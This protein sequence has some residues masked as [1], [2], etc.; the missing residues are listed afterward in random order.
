MKECADA[1]AKRRLERFEDL[2]VATS[3]DQPSSAVAPAYQLC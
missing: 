2:K 3:E 1:L